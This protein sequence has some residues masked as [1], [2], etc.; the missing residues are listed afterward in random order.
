MRTFLRA[1][2]LVAV[3]AV[4]TLLVMP[5]PAFAAESGAIA[6]VDAASDG[7]PG[8]G[9]VGGS[10][11]SDDG[12]Y[13][14]F[15]STSD[16]LVPGDTNDNTDIFVRDTETGTTT[17][18]SAGL[19]GQPANDGATY[20]AA[21][22][23]NGRYVAFTSYASNLVPGDTNN[24]RDVFVHDRQTG[25]TTLVSAF[26]GGRQIRGS[27]S[28]ATI[29]DDGRYTAFIVTSY[30]GDLDDQGLWLYGQ[31]AYVHDS[32]LGKT[33]RVS[34]QADGGSDLTAYEVAISGSGRQVAFSGSGDWI[35]DGGTSTGIF[36]HDL[37]SGATVRANL[38]A[39]E[40]EFRNGANPSISRDGTKVSWESYE[41]YVPTDTNAMGDVYVRD[42]TADTTVLVSA[43]RGSAGA[44]NSYSTSGRLAAGGRYV[45]FYSSAS[46]LAPRDGNGIASDVFVRDL[47]TGRTTAVSTTAAGATGNGESF[48]ANPSANGSRIVFSSRAT[49]LGVD[50]GDGHEHLFVRC[51]RNC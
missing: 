25:S 4:T 11:I 31:V 36:V 13:V 7:T 24:E 39:T 28:G 50:P 47:N 45:S 30:S 1:R 8:N 26:A 12:R 15:A 46:D 41:P 23:G 16:N 19:D 40:G 49:D 48:H 32:Q 9:G 51:L 6:L 34:P 43:S 18:V 3:T 42:L 10:D 20:T 27:S 5:A 35:G 29:S 38:P 17:L 22:S 37:T 33:T 14:A 21:I 44:G 2:A